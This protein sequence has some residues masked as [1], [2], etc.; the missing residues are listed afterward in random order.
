MNYTNIQIEQLKNLFASLDKALLVDELCNLDSYAI[1]EL[2]KNTRMGM[3]T[4]KKGNYK[5]FS[6][7]KNC[8]LSL[9]ID[10]DLKFFKDIIK[11]IE[12]V[13]LNE[14]EAEVFL[15]NGEMNIYVDNLLQ[16]KQQ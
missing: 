4:L 14:K 5:S 9:N 13:C 12:L 15:K 16:P 3:Y 1:S 11:C 7:I 6:V 10:Y 2:R 8:L